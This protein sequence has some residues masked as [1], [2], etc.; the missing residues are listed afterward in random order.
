M[1]FT[2]MGLSC[3]RGTDE[4]SPCSDDN[5]TYEQGLYIQGVQDQSVNLCLAHSLTFIVNFLT[6]INLG[7][8]RVPV[9]L[10]SGDETIIILHKLWRVDKHWKAYDVEI[11]AVSTLL[12]YRSQFKDILAKGT[13]SDLLSRLARPS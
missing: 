5:T 13:V 7:K 12:V 6:G 9:E 10:I 4:T 11:Q 8:L 2:N 3:E 1:K